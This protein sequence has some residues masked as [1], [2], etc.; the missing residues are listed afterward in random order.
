MQS[1]CLLNSGLEN[2]RCSLVFKMRNKFI[3]RMLYQRKKKEESQ[4][5]VWEF[6][7]LSEGTPWVQLDDLS[8]CQSALPRSPGKFS[9]VREKSGKMNYWHPETTITWN[10]QKIFKIFL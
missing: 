8:L 3:F 7:R 4:R 10:L 5:K 1:V 9:E 6:D 2:S